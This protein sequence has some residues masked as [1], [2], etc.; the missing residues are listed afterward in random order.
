MVARRD[1][2]L[3]RLLALADVA[4]GAIAMLSLGALFGGDPTQSLW[5]ILILPVWIVMAKLHGLYD[6][7]QRSLR[8]LT[9]DELPALLMWATSSTALLALFLVAVPVEPPTAAVAIRAW[10]LAWTCAFVFRALVRATWRRVTPPQRT[11][12]VGGG[13]SAAA[14]RRKLELFDDIHAE[15]VAER[16]EP[17]L[18]D[19]IDAPYWLDGIDRVVV[20]SQSMDEPVA[21]ELVAACRERQIK[22]SIVPPIP[23]LFGTAVQPNHV[24]D[25]PIV[26]YSTWHVSRSTLMLKR[27]FDVVVAVPALLVTLPLFVAISIAIVIDS[28]GPIMF[29][30]LRATINARPFKML[31]FRTMVANAEDLLPDLISIDR[32]P[33]PVFKLSD[34]PRITRV[35]RFLRRTSLDEL[36]QLWNVLRGDMSLVGPRPEQVEIVARYSP[37]HRVRLAV[38][39]GLTGPMQVFGRGELTFEERLAVEREY[40]ETIS[41]RR[42]L[43]IMTMTLSAIVSRRGAS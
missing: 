23:A 17:T 8:H 10:L 13:P 4:A 26:E 7:D 41:L 16:P 20:A 28:R 15:V 31:K 19:M 40:V 1:G 43:R 25:L 35:G 34:D 33:E 14:V 42:D 18:D 5:A 27:V 3:R 36:P 11:L 12:I 39:A 30:Q 22:L 32:L 9:V 37:E 6:H 29:T 2:T 38:K 21:S 24:A